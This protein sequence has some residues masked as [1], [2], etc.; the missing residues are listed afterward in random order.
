MGSIARLMQT[1]SGAKPEQM[2]ARRVQISQLHLPDV[3][4]SQNVE[5]L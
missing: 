4:Y 2:V 3:E 5:A 1:L